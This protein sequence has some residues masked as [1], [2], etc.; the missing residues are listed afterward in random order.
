MGFKEVFLI[1]FIVGA[2]SAQN[3]YKVCVQGIQPSVCQSI[4]K[5]DSQ[6]SC[7]QL[8]SRVD[9]ALKLA[10][11]EADIGYFSEEETILIG[12][13]QPNN[14]RVI[15][16]IRDANK[17]DPYAFEAVAIVPSNHTNG[18]EGLRGGVY[19]HPGLDQTEFRWSPRVLKTLEEL[20][21]R[22]DRCHDIQTSGKTAEEVE[23]ET[24]SR[25]FSSGCRPGSWSANATVD[26]A[27]KARFPSLCSLCGPD[28]GC[29]RYT[30]DMGVSIAGANNQNRHIQALEC[31]R[32]NGNGAQPAVAYVAW[33]HAREYFSIRNPQDASFFS[34]LCS[35]GTLAPLTT[36]TLGNSIS[37]CALVRQPWGTIV[38]HADVA[39]TLLT[40]LRTWW[41]E[42]AD[43]GS[44][45]WQSIFYNA[46]VTPAGGASARVVFED[47]P[48]FPLN[49]TQAIRPVSTVDSTPTCI[50]ARRW[51]V[52]SAA[53]L[54]KCN[55]VR[56]ASHIL[57]IQPPI[58]CQRG[59]NIFECLSDI[60]DDKADFIS[61]GANYGYIA[62]QHYKLTPVKLVQNPQTESYRVA[63]FVKNNATISEN[64]TRFENLRG[65]KACF[66]EFGGLA[67]MAFVRAGQQRGV[68]PQ[69][70][71]DYAKVV[72]EFFD[73]ACAPGAS[74]AS[75][76]IFDG[77][78]FDSS[79]LCSQC[80]PAYPV[81]GNFSNQ[82]CSWDYSNQFFGNNGSLAC[83][84]DP[85]NDVAFLNMRSISTHLT[86]LG[87]QANDFRALCVNNSLA[88][89]PGVN[90]PDSCLLTLVVDAEVLTR[91][92]DPF[93]NSLN[94]LFDSLDEYFGYN[95]AN[96]RQ[97]INL[98]IFSPFGGN[99][100][101]LFKDTTIGLTEPTRASTHA[102]AR[103]YI[104]LFEHL[105]ACTGAAPG[106]A[107]RNFYS[108]IALIVTS[109]LTRF[110]IA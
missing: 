1:A 110:V 85:S 79:V 102:P 33:Q 101:L 71:C 36:E 32:V 13:R 34:V 80:Q 83:L 51:C 40:S 81:L 91:R 4:A 17:L 7:T 82:V 88:D 38:A 72:G 64:I 105:Q 100:D 92:N 60:K 26:A 108:V 15:A 104:E 27:L 84:A 6:V 29:S 58:S 68:L 95:A 39:Q 98:E 42:G 24:I 59:E 45:S 44:N 53:E 67:Y 76:A 77:S 69:S 49:Y 78:S 12:Q 16:T 103:N 28:S 37:P 30:I 63:A 93:Y 3:N 75:H 5:D 61:A 55:W 9:C 10:T 46:V 41:P 97:L 31:L 66:P 73:G 23:V 25:F 48:I 2:A 65:K 70:E 18:L 56:S 106:T 11:K 47:A 43:P 62:R 96:A 90:I 74:D 52:L 22:T 14:H 57:G 35:N 86:S 21:A 99:K 87:L 19:C 20:A 50:P 109:I 54:E 107:S 94:V 8:E 89:T